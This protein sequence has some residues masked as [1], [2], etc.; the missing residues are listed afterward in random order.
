MRI[1]TSK[2]KICRHL[3]ERC[4]LPKCPVAKSANPPRQLVS[5]GHFLVNGAHVNVPSYGVKVGDLI[6]IR[7]SSSKNKYFQAVVEIVKKHKY[8]SWITFNTQTLE[9]KVVGLPT[10]EE[11]SLPYNLQLITEYYSK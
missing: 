1:T 2:H 11:V 5:H 4:D 6:T 10:S 8:P 7:P 3:G 9:A